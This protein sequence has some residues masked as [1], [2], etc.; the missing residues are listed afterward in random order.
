MKYRRIAEE[1]ADHFRASGIGLR[2]LMDARE[3]VDLMAARL[4]AA[5]RPPRSEQTRLENAEAVGGLA[6][7]L[8]ARAEI[9]RLAGEPV[10]RLLVEC[11]NSLTVDFDS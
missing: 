4:A 11:L 10:L 1:L 3:A 7:R 8:A 2:Q 9:A 5:A 6:G